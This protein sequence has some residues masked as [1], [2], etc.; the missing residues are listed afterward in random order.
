M[1]VSGAA[2]WVILVFLCHQLHILNSA[3]TSEHITIQ[4]IGNSD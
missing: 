4:V 1:Y 3:F 2:V